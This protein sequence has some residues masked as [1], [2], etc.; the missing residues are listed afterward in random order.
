MNYRVEVR[1]HDAKTRKT[2]TSIS[3]PAVLQKER[4]HS[5]G[6][7]VYFPLSVGAE[8]NCEALLPF[9]P[10]AEVESAHGDR[11]AWLGDYMKEDTDGV[12]RAPLLHWSSWAVIRV[13]AAHWGYIELDHYVL[14][15]VQDSGME[16][17]WKR[18]VCEKKAVEEIGSCGLEL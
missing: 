16:V 14:G 7:E 6:E 5:E 17:Q 12:P 10:D 3:E 13:E 9:L 2:S 11:I 18:K 1:M 8:S 15:A 4:R